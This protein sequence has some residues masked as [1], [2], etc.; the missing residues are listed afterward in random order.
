MRAPARSARAR[1]SRRPKRSSARRVR[2]PRLASARSPCARVHAGDRKAHLVAHRARFVR[3]NRGLPLLHAL[4]LFLVALLRAPRDQLIPVVHDSPHRGECG[5]ARDRVVAARR[6]VDVLE[7][8]GRVLAVEAAVVQRHEHLRRA[9]LA[10]AEERLGQVR[11]LR[12]FAVAVGGVALEGG[13]GRVSVLGHPQRTGEA[14]RGEPRPELAVSPHHRVDRA[15]QVHVRDVEL[16]DGVGAR[17]VEH[18][19]EPPRLVGLH[20]AAEQDLRAGRLVPDRVEGRAQHPG[21]LLGGPVERPVAVRLVPDLPV[22]DHAGG[23][24]RHFPAQPAVVLLVRPVG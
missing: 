24:L 18:A 8:L 1:S 21:V 13:V 9:R 5:A 7:P 3:G 20:Q 16:V 19:L 15:A 14:A 4:L 22:I 10:E 17:R 6:L 12:G 23:V 11:A 2:L